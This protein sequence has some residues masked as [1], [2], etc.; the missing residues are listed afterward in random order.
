M[1]FVVVKSM[2]NMSICFVLDIANS[3]TE[4][5]IFTEQKPEV[6]QELYT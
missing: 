1:V 3:R 5:A 4:S 6:Q 2:R